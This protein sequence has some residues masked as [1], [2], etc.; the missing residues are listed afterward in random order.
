MGASAARQVAACPEQG[1]TTRFFFFL[2]RWRVCVRVP[3]GDGIDNAEHN[4]KVIEQYLT[5]Q[6]RWS[7]DV[8]KALHQGV[9][10]LGAGSRSFLLFFF[11]SFFNSIH[12]GNRLWQSGLIP[13]EHI[14]IQFHPCIDAFTTLWIKRNK[15]ATRSRVAVNKSLLISPI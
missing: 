9:L 15:S 5:K 8:I 1:E 11:F 14:W 13:L 6:P 12:S 3:T 7:S 4:G 2:C 10:L